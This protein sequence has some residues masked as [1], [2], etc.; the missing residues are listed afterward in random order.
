MKVGVL[1]SGEV[2]RTLASGLLKHGYEVKL[3]SRSPEKLAEWA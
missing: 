1:G 3:G 2:A